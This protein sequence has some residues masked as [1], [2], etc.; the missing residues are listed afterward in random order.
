MAVKRFSMNKLIR[1]QIPKLL[2]AKGFLMHNQVLEK[3]EFIQKLK[4]K[5]KEE[6]LEVIHSQTK[7]ELVEELADVLEVVHA[8]SEALDVSLEHI[9]GKRLEK[10]HQK[11]GFEG[12]MF[13]HYVEI[14]EDNAA[15]TYFS[16]HQ[17][18]KY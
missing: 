2:Q 13:N 1:D 15:I 9:E 8:L 3:E 5:L 12:R 7:S 6:C 11:G 10:R 4:D 18:Q 16:R 14:E 17:E